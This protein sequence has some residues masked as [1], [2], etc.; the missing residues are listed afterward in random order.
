VSE[1]SATLTV[2]ATKDGYSRSAKC[3]VTVNEPKVVLTSS[4]I[5][6][7]GIGVVDKTTDVNASHFADTVTY[8]V[9]S[10]NTSIATGAVVSDILNISTVAEGTTTL[11]VTASAAGVSK[12]ASIA[13]TVIASARVN[14][15]SVTGT[16]S[17]AVGQSVS[18]T[19]FVSVTGDI[20]ET[21]NWSSSASGIASVNSSGSVTGVAAGSATITATSTADSTKSGSLDVTVTATA[22][23]AW[24]IMIYMCGADLESN[25]QTSASSAS[26]YATGDLK[27]IYNTRASLPSNVNVIVEAGGAKSWKTTYSSVISTSYLNRFH[28][29]TSG[30][31]K[32]EQITKANMGLASTFQSFL[33]WGLTSYPADRTM[34]V[35]WD[36]GGA[37]HGCCYDENYNDDA[38]LNSE[39]HSAL[40]GAFTSTGRT[41]KLECI[42]YDACLMQVQDVAEFNSEYFNYMVASEESEAGAGWDYD[43]GWLTSIYS[44]PT[45]VTTS[46]VLTSVVNTFITDN[47]GTSSTSDQTLSWLNLNQMATYK[48]AWE[49]MAA[50]LNSNVLTSSNKSAFQT[51]VKGCKRYAVDSDNSQDYFATIDAKDFLTKLLA[52]STFNTGSVSTYVQAVQS[53]FSNLVGYS[54]CQKGAGNS[55]GLCMFFSLSSDAS[56]GTYY[57]ADQT[58]FTNW[59]TT[60]NSFGV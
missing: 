25:G 38:L 24:T 37:M 48:T 49:N 27:E 23:D 4:S 51:L 60:N 17:L 59:R 14:S 21:V 26:G 33:E 46:S 42:G 22:Q 47:G 40:S 35:F 2:K 10:G 7:V 45:T 18:L 16:S 8:S 39:V 12:T 20:A 5:T 50:Y 32:D 54:S 56:K 31:T 58:N 57:A 55:Y 41:S 53:A 11:I 19:A 30:Y 9:S 13:V 29:T 6:V 1:G 52:S 3:V 44:N 34:V 28:L 43:G 15:V 36:H